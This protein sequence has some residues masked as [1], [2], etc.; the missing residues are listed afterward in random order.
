MKEWNVGC[1]A[2]LLSDYQDIAAG[3]TDRKVSWEGCQE[4]TGGVRKEVGYRVAPYLKI[5]YK[6]TCAKLKKYL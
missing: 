4:G 1:A 2:Y 6:E 5:L 3:V